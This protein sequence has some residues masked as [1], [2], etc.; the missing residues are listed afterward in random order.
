[1]WKK[2]AIQ[3]KDRDATTKAKNETK[4]NV[5]GAV[6]LIVFMLFFNGFLWPETKLI[7]RGK[8]VGLV[9]PIGFFFVLP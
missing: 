9:G 2:P 7:F 3:G 5:I 4:Q 6:V 8:P 1:M